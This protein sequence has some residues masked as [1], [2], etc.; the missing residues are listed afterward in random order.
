MVKK[1]KNHFE[2]ISFEV[3]TKMGTLIQLILALAI[4]MCIFNG[5]PKTEASILDDIET[6][7]KRINKPEAKE[8]CHELMSVLSS[9]SSEA[10]DSSRAQ[11]VSESNLRSLIP[12]LTALLDKDSSPKSVWQAAVE[13][14]N[15]NDGL[16]DLS[17]NWIS[18][19]VDARLMHPMRGKRIRF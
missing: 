9:Y 17:K 13:D 10:I 7:C 18:R 12:K 6:D 3:S 1:L 19:L 4:T 8:V 2:N 16:N 5:T 11:P 14:K 15:Y